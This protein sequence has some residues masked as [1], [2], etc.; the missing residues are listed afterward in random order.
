VI[1]AMAWMVTPSRGAA[2]PAFMAGALGAVVLVRA[3]EGAGPLLSVERTRALAAAAAVIAAAVVAWNFWDIRSNTVF[4]P[5]RPVR[6]LTEDLREVAP[7]LRGIRSDPAT[8]A[9]LRAVGGCVHAFPARRTAILPEDAFSSSVFGLHNPFP[10]DWLWPDE[11]QT[12]GA[13]DRI[14]A[15]ARRMAREG[16]YL[17]LVPLVPQAAL[18]GDP[19]PTLP[20][21]KRRDPIP[22]FPFDAGLGQEI[23]AALD[24]GEHIACGPFV[25]RYER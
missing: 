23:L 5:Q 15:A 18:S 17:V 3:W 6:L 11:Y 22:A 24:G 14:V 4:L 20:T 16:G 12:P 21:A 7:A 8:A 1:V 10:M 25:G 2:R 13:R 9:Y 19:P